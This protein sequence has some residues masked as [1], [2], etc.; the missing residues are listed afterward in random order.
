MLNKTVRSSRCASYVALP[1][2]LAKSKNITVKLILE[3][4]K[5]ENSINISQ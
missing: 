3:D 1:S 4:A 2:L 5:L